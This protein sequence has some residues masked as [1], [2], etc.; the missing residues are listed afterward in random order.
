MT[1]CAPSVAEAN[2][3]YAS[4][5]LSIVAAAAARIHHERQRVP[6]RIIAPFTVCLLN[7]YHVYSFTIKTNILPSC[8]NSTFCFLVESLTPLL[9]LSVNV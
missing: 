7:I 3:L 5:L 8:V 1:R 6:R 2:E 4:R 9:E